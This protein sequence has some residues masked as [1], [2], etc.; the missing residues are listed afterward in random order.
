MQII[1]QIL[2]IFNGLNNIFIHGPQEIPKWHELY[3]KK[4]YR[5]G[6]YTR[7][8]LLFDRVKVTFIIYRFYDPMNVL[9][10][11]IADLKL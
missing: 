6:T 10:R 7:S 8:L 2:T 1:T 9:E 5:C 11:V 4:Y 3:G